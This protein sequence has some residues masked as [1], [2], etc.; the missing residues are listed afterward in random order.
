M[1]V[2]SLEDVRL[3]RSFGPKFLPRRQQL[4]HHHK[5]TAEIPRMW[6]K[7][8]KKKKKK[9]M[10]WEEFGYERL[11]EKLNQIWATFEQIFWEAWAWANHKASKC[12]GVWA[13]AKTGIRCS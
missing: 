4:R 8:K 10:V 13:H 5:N 6:K 3:R 2:S 11:R 1:L 12:G 9:K 7:K